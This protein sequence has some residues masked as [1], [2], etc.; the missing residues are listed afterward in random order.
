MEAAK[1][2]F[3]PGLSLAGLLAVTTAAAAVLYFLDPATVRIYPVCYFHQ[4][5]GWQCPGCGGLR[6]A[7][8]LLHGNVREAFQ[9]NAFAVLAAPLFGWLCV[10]F[11]FR[12][13]RQQPSSFTVRPAWLWTGLAALVL[14]GFLRNVLG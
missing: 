12:T 14:F 5:T 6:A 13:F 1:T 2:K 10:R 7:H 9:L 3:F 4:F 8:Q 11:V